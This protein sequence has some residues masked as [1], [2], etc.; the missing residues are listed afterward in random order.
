MISNHRILYSKFIWLAI[1]HCLLLTIVLSWCHL[2]H[3]LYYL[4]CYCAGEFSPIIIADCSFDIVC[5]TWWYPP[6]IGWSTPFAFHLIIYLVWNSNHFI[7][8]I[9]SCDLVIASLCHSG[10]K[11]GLFRPALQ[12][13]NVQLDFCRCEYLHHDSLDSELV[14]FVWMLPLH[15]GTRHPGSISKKKTKRGGMMCSVRSCGYTCWLNGCSLVQR[16]CS[17]SRDQV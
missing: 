8:F 2:H 14:R 6:L 11:P 4:C 16:P 10:D 5:M 12:F 9:A 13:Q 1:T 17:P 15:M 7:S 3:L